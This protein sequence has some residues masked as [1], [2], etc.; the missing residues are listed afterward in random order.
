M[1]TALEAGTLISNGLAG[2]LAA[3]QWRK[4]QGK[5]VMEKELSLA[6]R[7]YQGVRD[8][9]GVTVYGNFENSLRAPIVTL[10]LYD[11][12]SGAVG[13]ELFLRFGI[14]TRTGGHCAPLYHLALGTEKQGAVR[15]SFSYYNTEEEADLAAAAVKTLAEEG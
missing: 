8:L 6:A 9:P 15:F 5:K 1:P 2:L 3:L 14:Q 7:F 4:S 12:D 11:Y 10:N 13:E